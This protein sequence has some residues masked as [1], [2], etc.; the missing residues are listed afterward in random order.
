MVTLTAFER[1]IWDQTTSLSPPKPADD[2]HLGDAF[3]YACW[4][5]YVSNAESQGSGRRHRGFSRHS[6]I[7]SKLIRGKV[8]HWYGDIVDIP[9]QEMRHLPSTLYPVTDDNYR[10]C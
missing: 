9:G 4:V 3:V 7:R 6:S 2:G 5:K 8:L 10:K 1:R